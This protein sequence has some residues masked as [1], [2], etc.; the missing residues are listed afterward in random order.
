MRVWA[1]VSDNILDKC[2][3]AIDRSSS[4]IPI[5]TH[6]HTHTHTHAHAHTHTHTHTQLSTTTCVGLTNVFNAYAV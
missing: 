6:T 1:F 2:V 5:H 3:F 4:A